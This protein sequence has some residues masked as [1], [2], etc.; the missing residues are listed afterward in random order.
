[1]DPNDKGKAA[2]KSE[3]QPPQLKQLVSALTPLRVPVQEHAS[4]SSTSPSTRT[5]SPLDSPLRLRDPASSS[6]ST[7]QFTPAAESPVKRMLRQQASLSPTK[8]KVQESRES[9]P[10]RAP[11]SRPQVLPHPDHEQHYDHQHHNENEQHDEE[12]VVYCYICSRTE[13]SSAPASPFILL[14]P[15]AEYTIIFS[16]A[17]IGFSFFQGE[18]TGYEEVQVEEGL[19]E[20]ESFLKGENEDMMV[21]N[22]G[23]KEVMWRMGTCLT[24]RFAL[25]LEGSDVGGNSNLCGQSSESEVRVTD[26]PDTLFYMRDNDTDPIAGPTTQPIT[27]PTD[28]NTRPKRTKRHPAKFHNHLI[29][30]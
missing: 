25:V 29:Y 12:G 20:V 8:E 10:R 6:L 22:S 15:F 11:Y 9:S 18:E 13:A 24:W 7:M 14:R 4:S 21:G 28:D 19:V 1:M 27:Q 17:K 26:H 30:K 2:A 5:L 3:E 23:L 16:E